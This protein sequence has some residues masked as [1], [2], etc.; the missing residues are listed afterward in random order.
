[1]L[2]A[3]I[4]F[5]LLMGALTNDSI[6]MM[7]SQTWDY[8]RHDTFTGFCRELRDDT[9]PEVQ[10]P[11]A[12]F[13]FWGWSRLVGTGELAL[14]SLN[15]LWAAI[16][17]AALARAGRQLSLPWLPILFA[18]QPFVW[19]YMNYA[20]TPVMQ[21]AGGALLV[22]G[23]IGFVLRVSQDGT[24]AILLCFG[25]ILLSGASIFGLVPLFSVAI[26]L[27]AHGFWRTLRLPVAGK[28]LLF[29]TLSI[30][31]V[32]G[33]YYA[34][35][36]LRGLG[37]N[38]HWS[39]SPA[40]VLFVI[41]EF[42]GFQGV[43]LG[44]QELRAIIKSLAPARELLHFIP[45]LLILGVAYLA[46]LATAFKSWMTREQRPVPSATCQVAASIKH[47]VCF[48]LRGHS[49]IPVWLMGLGVPIFSAAILLLVAWVLGVPFW[50]RHLAGSFP[51]WVV[52]LAIT[53]HWAR[54][55]LWR[56][57]GR[58][59][60]SALLLLL[61]A[62]SLLIRFAP[63]HRHDDYRGAVAEATRVFSGGGVVLWV[64]DH[65]GGAYYGLPLTGKVS[66]IRGEIQFPMNQAGSENPDAII[67][68]RP[69]TFDLRDTA[70]RMIATGAYRKTR[71]LQAFE[72]WEKISDE[73]R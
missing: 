51:F 5:V 58:S 40:N 9:S 42:L 38:S 37:G 33:V 66:G 57:V 8:A 3:V 15:L 59:A 56:K 41:Y 69:D 45:G 24:D 61:L 6:D 28:I 70:T 54:Q 11:L 64:A 55:G 49:F 16:A 47:S 48:P 31:V 50:G 67:I 35:T 22:A 29:L 25:A 14:R 12:M 46:I 2:W 72:I 10:M 53:I 18:V 21:M 68:S 39:V 60:G 44:R 34:S 27:V 17:L 63:F 20:R 30:L 26:G 71:M 23:A 52:A 1:M 4:G 65:S 36:L 13:S 7:E 32:L 43:G 19:Y 62:S 73:T